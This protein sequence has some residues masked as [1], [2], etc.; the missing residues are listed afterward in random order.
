MTTWKLPLESLQSKQPMETGME[1]RSTDRLKNLE[2]IKVLFDGM[3]NL[4]IWLSLV[5]SLQYVQRLTEFFDAPLFVKVL[6]NWLVAIFLLG[7]A[8]AAIYWLRYSYK[9][10]GWRWFDYVIVYGVMSVAFFI[11]GVILGY[12]LPDVQFNPFVDH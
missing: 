3:K 11:M 8:A 12:Q 4:A 9:P 6:A 7:V 2:N 1:N 10:E 5:F